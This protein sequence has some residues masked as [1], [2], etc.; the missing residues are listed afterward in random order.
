MLS[1]RERVR[2]V[3]NAV[4]LTLCCCYVALTFIDKYRADRAFV[5]AL[6]EQQIHA[7]RLMTAPTPLNNVLWYCLAETDEGYWTAYYSLLDRGRQMQWKFIPRN[8]QTLTGIRQTELI[9]RLIW[10]SDGYYAV[11]AER[12]RLLFDVLKFGTFP[13]GPE[14]SEQTAF[15][16]AIERDA[17]GEL[18]AVN[19]TRRHNIDVRHAAATLWKRIWGDAL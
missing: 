6:A 16:F 12:G 5:A 13:L 17:G 4:G 7:T 15:T 3:V 1:R 9:R 18:Q 2:R 14:G 11:R 8:G 10:F 19:L